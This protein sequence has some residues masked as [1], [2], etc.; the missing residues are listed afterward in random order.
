[1][2]QNNFMCHKH[3]TMLGY[4]HT[5]RL[6]QANWRHPRHRLLQTHMEDI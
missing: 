5:T 6:P 1:L 4:P 2:L 3:E